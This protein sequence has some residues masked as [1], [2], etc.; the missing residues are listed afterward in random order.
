MLSL[1]KVWSISRVIRCLNKLSNNRS[2]RTHCSSSNNQ[3]SIIFNK[4]LKKNTSS[5]M[6][7]KIKLKTIFKYYQYNPMYV[8]V[9]LADPEHLSKGQQINNYMLRYKHL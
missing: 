2:R 6:E 1:K 7:N 8:E 5:Y 4:T 9:P 3:Q